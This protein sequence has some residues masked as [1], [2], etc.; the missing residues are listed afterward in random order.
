[1]AI[2][3]QIFIYILYFLSGPL[4]W[5]FLVWG[6]HSSKKR[7]RLFRNPPDEVPTPAPLVTILVPAKDEGERIRPCLN[8]ILALDYPNFQLIAI[9]D[10]SSDNT[11]Q[12]L[13]EMAAADP[14]VLAVHIK[15]G[16]LPP[17]WTGKNHALYV[18]AQKAKGDW[19]LF[20]DAD[21]IVYPPALR[22]T[23]GT[24]IARLFDM[25]SL[26][27]RMEFHSF[28]EG[29]M[30]PLGGM[31][32]ATLHL[33]PLCNTN[34]APKIGFANGQFMLVKRS[35]YDAIGG[36]ERV[37]NIYGEDVALAR[38]LKING[39]RPRVTMGADLCQV[40]MFDSFQKILRGWAR[41][42]FASAESVWRNITGLVILLIAGYG[43]IPAAIWGIYE[44]SHAA[45][46]P[47][48]N[49]WGNTSANIWGNIWLATAVLHFVL[50]SVD[51]GIMYYMT[52]TRWWYALFFLPLSGPLLV[53]VMARS[54][55]LSFSKRLEWRGTSYTAGSTI[56][57]SPVTGR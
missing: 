1:M 57:Q 36:H 12:I 47:E 17:R 4:V 43:V 2:A 28:W 44:R 53:Y 33:A 40:R 18:G 19:L 10:R 24:A 27:P 52:R 7:M 6:L 32:T 8:S 14:R 45:G 13:N 46:F 3:V 21:V 39:F 9:N 48:G 56:N 51:L 35:A 11:G 41:I 37:R 42:L 55:R 25:V 50:I 26:M 16:E 31:M 49:I 23:L 20:I 5:A 29:V 38:A 22:R 34:G 30:T 54:I 15:D